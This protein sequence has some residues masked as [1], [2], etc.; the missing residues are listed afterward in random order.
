MSTISD[1]GLTGLLGGATSGAAAANNAQQNMLNQQD[2]FSLMIAQFQNQD[3]FKPMESGEFL[4][5]IAQ[6]STVDG[7]YGLNE[8]FGD[9]QTQLTS[10]QALQASTLIDRDVLVPTSTVRYPGTGSVSGHVDVPLG[11]DRVTVEIVDGT[12]HTVRS[13]S[14][15]GSVLDETFEFSWDGLDAEGQAVPAADYTVRV[16]AG[17]GE[18]EVALT[19]ELAGRVDA[20]RMGASGLLLEVAGFGDVPFSTVTRIA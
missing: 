2:F 11:A 4:G 15:A 17:Q 8:S 6:F 13:Y 10:D 5:Q 7:I 18:Q 19:P 1:S 9:L 20:V 3:P 14:A 16:R 12:G